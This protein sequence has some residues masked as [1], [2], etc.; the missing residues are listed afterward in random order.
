[1]GIHII[2]ELLGNIQLIHIL[3]EL[4]YGMQLNL[5]PILAYFAKSA[6]KLIKP[7]NIA[8]NTI[9]KRLIQRLHLLRVLIPHIIRVLL[10]LL[11]ISF[12]ALLIR[13]LHLSFA[14]Q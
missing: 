4:L 13:R 8:G 14:I 12:K 2:I 3:L 7:L 5:G 1:M 9:L 11:V 6:H 10:Q